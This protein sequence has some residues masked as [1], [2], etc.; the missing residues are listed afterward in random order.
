MLR[1][2][3]ILTAPAL[4]LL[5]I[6][7]VMLLKPPAEPAAPLAAAPAMRTADRPVPPIDAAAPQVVETATFAYG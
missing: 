7:G 4:V 2:N 6:G 3:L 5:A 1:I